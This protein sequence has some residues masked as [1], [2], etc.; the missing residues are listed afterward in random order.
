T[1]PLAIGP[2]SLVVDQTNGRLLVAVWEG[3]AA[4]RSIIAIDGLPRLFDLY[5]SYEPAAS[6]WS[7]TVPRHPEG[8]LAADYFDTYYGDLGTVGDWS[9]A[10]PLQCAYPATPPSVGDYLEVPDPLPNPDPGHGRYYVTAVHHGG[11][12]RYGRKSTGGVL[13]G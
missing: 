2:N 11:E 9:Q 8:L 10:Q 4:P 1:T 12:T 6:S 13:S 3:G 7:F 5:Q